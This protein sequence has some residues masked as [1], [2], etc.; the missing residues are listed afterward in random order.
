M[1]TKFKNAREFS[2]REENDNKKGKT[3]RENRKRKSNKQE[4]TRLEISTTFQKPDIE[5]GST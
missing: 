1:V 5:Y 4:K 2:K 3:N